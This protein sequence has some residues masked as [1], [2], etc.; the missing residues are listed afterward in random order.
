MVYNTRLYIG[1]SNQSENEK[2]K[3]KVERLSKTGL[4]VKNLNYEIIY[5]GT[6]TNITKPV[7]KIKVFYENQT[8]VKVPFISNTKYDRVPTGSTGTADLLIDPSDFSNY[9][10]DFEIV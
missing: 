3:E 7:Y 1:I 10:I 2:E 4:L 5:I 6:Q 9:Y 8:G